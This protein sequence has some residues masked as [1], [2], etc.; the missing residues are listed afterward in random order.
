MCR[1][2]GFHANEPT[3]IECSLI[4][5]QNALMAQSIRDREGLTNGHGW[6]VAGYPDGIPFVEKQAWAAYH[7]EHF[8]KTATRVYARTVI[9]H[10]RR[11]TVGPPAIENTHPFEHG[12]WLFAHNGTVPNFDAIRRWML[13]A[14]DPLHRNEIRGTTDSEHI[15]RY[16]LS[17]EM[18]APERA[19]RETLHEGLRQI[20]LWSMEVDPDARISLNVLWTD[21]D[22]LVGSRLNR[23]LW[24]LERNEI[25]H[26]PV[27]GQPHVHHSSKRDYRAVEVASE[28]ITDEAWLGVPNGT[29]FSIDPDIF[30]HIEPMAPELLECVTP[31]AAD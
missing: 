23:T 15:F 14:M 12:R 24:Y 7:G 1:L 28:P 22:H 8:K 2:Y 10:V 31:A 13:E 25:I 26:C 6:G 17:L 18:R 11:A 9:A 5:A 19:L 3:R 29:V 27:C 16:L 4:H 21:G 20:V 30:M